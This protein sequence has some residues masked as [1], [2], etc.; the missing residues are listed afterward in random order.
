MPPSMLE[1]K[2][3]H[4][5]LCHTRTAATV[6]THHHRRRLWIESREPGGCLTHG[7]CL[8]TAYKRNRMFVWFTHVDED[9]RF[10]TLLH[11]MHVMDSDGFDHCGLLCIHKTVPL[12][13]KRHCRDDRYD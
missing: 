12:R 2:A 5:G 3:R 9:E 10:T 1:S 11:G 4:Q 13:V 8:C 7:V 6:M